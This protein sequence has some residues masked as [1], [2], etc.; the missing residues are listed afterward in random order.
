MD[1]G[2]LGQGQGRFRRPKEKGILPL[3]L[4][5]PPRHNGCASNAA[6]GVMQIQSEGLPV[7]SP[8]S[9][10]V[11]DDVES[12]R[13]R[14]DVLA[15]RQKRLADL[16]ECPPEK[17]EHEIRNILNELRLL[18]ARC[19]RIRKGN[20]WCCVSPRRRD[21]AEFVE[22]KRPIKVFDAA[23]PSAWARTTIQPR[24]STQG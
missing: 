8:P 1:A 18:R 7:E 13:K 11:S 4:R 6:V 22:V 14:H 9:S 10:P 17:I 23:S 3:T 2:R 21:S 24:Q 20:R 19:L 16:L 5:W 15:E 12:L